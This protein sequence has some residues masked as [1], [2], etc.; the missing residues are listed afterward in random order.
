MFLEVGS[1]KLWIMDLPIL[2]EKQLVEALKAGSLGA[3][4]RLYDAY[5]GYLYHFSLKFLKSSGLAEE[6]VHDVFLK[7]WETR[8][9][10]DPERSLKP[11]LSTICKNHIFNLLKRANR[12]EAV[13]DEI[14]RSLAEVYNPTEEA[15]FGTELEQI[16]DQII[17]QLPAQRQR[18]FR[19]Y[20]FEE[21]DLDAIARELQISKGTVKDHMAKANRFVR[22][23]L[24]LQ[25]GILFGLSILALFFLR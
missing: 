11:Y 16:V 15:L 24:K 19:M 17:G 1:K 14:R 5:H 4:T 12:E 10:L 3:F 21:L 6:V 22:R 20:R 13:M 9:K 25:T 8:T 23:N 2:D 7:L 18:V